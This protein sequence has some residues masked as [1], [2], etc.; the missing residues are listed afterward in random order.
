MHER[1]LRMYYSTLDRLT[2]DCVWPVLQRYRARLDRCFCERHY[3][4]GAHLRV[5]LGGDESAS[6]EAAA[7]LHEAACTYI[8]EH[9]SPP[10]AYS[11]HAA[12]SMLAREGEPVLSDELEYRNN[13]VAA[14]A[15]PPRHYAYASE[16]AEALSNEFRH[17]A[18]PLAIAIMRAA[19]RRRQMLSLYASYALL[20][21][22]GDLAAGSVSLK[23]HWE[24]FAFALPDASLVERV[25]AVE[26]RHASELLSTL[27]EVVHRHAAGTIGESPV[28]DEWNTLF[29]K[30]FE[31][32]S[33]IFAQGQ[34]LSY[35]P[36][37]LAHVGRLRDK[38]FASQRRSSGFMDALFA[39][40]RYLA[41]VQYE[42]SFLRTRVM[43]NLLYILVALAG[44]NALDR[45]CFCY[46]TWRTVERHCDCDLTDVLRH[47]VSRVVQR[48]VARGAFEP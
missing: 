7:T 48:Y 36:A 12:Q 19:D 2:L 40:P 23:S 35:Q 25:E 6:R 46:L 10:K 31:R 21:G 15:P 43:T 32:A 20:V 4:G 34:S 9:P 38:T 5:S 41:S 3:A 33:A 22:K 13:S 37:D 8:S 30:Y 29:H 14:S 27:R 11:F 17:D 16:T 18:M 26:R 44:F 47:N 28:L 39:D 45:Q 24:G 42:P 1:H